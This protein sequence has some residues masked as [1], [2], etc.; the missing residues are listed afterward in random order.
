MPPAARRRRPPALHVG[1]VVAAGVHLDDVVEGGAPA[2][3]VG[4]VGPGELEVGRLL[5][6]VGALLR[7]DDAVRDGLVGALLSSLPSGCR[8]RGVTRKPSGVIRATTHH[9]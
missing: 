2:A 8:G 3:H 7:G 1:V 4:Q 6:A 9:G 5:R